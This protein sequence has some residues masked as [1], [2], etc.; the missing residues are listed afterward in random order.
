MAKK[1]VK[2]LKG[3]VKDSD[4]GAVINTNSSVF[5]A[6]RKQKQMVQDKDNQIAQ[7]QDDINELKKSICLLYIHTH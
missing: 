2:E 1:K 4:T 7:M 5:E 3:F 6:R